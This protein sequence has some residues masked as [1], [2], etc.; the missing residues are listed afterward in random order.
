[1]GNS[2]RNLFHLFI[3]FIVCPPSLN[4]GLFEDRALSF[5]F[6]KL[7]AEPVWSGIFINA[8]EQ[9]FLRPLSEFTMTVF[10]RLQIILVKRQKMAIQYKYFAIK[11]YDAKV[12]WF[13]TEKQC[14]FFVIILKST[15]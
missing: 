6:R 10:S 11:L 13:C 5:V 4:E 2:C 9:L 8:Q 14:P 7:E 15:A 3:F 1:M 12:Q